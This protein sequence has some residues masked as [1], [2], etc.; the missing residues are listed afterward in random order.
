MLYNDPEHS[1]E[2]AEEARKLSRKMT[3]PAGKE[4][5]MEI[6]DRYDRLAARAVGRLSQSAG[7]RRISRHGS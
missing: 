5:M 4:L 1:G 7:E 3:D 6:A 2:R